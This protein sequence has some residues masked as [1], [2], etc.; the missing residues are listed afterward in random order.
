MKVFVSVKTSANCWRRY[1]AETIRDAVA[2]AKM[3]PKES[4]IVWTPD[5]AADMQRELK[6]GRYWA[7]QMWHDFDIAA[8]KA[9]ST[10]QRHYAR[11]IRAS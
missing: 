7:R 3:M 8:S 6:R 9:K 1:R 10:A 2:L 5:S 4:R 11:L